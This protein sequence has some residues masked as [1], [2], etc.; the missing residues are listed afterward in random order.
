MPGGDSSSFGGD[1]NH[2]FSFNVGP[3]HFIS[4]ST[5]FYYYL[6]Y[7]VEQVANQFAWLEQNLKVLLKLNY[8]F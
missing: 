2:F 5:E 1:N 6:E 3:V 8:L 4:F 7:G